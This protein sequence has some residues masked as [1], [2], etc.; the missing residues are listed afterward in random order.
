MLEKINRQ[1]N[2]IRKLKLL[3]L[4]DSLNILPHG[5]LT[6]LDIL[7]KASESH[8]GQYITVSDIAKQ[9]GVTRPA[10]SRTLRKLEMKGCIQ[11]LTDRQDRRITYVLITEDGRTALN[12]NIEIITSFMNRV[13]SHFEPNEIDEY[14]NLSKKLV[15]SITEE[16][17]LLLK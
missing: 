5:E 16:E 13:F 17:K 4:S 11:R 9:L 10:I 6:I 2:I 8:P 7:W 15:D 1:Y 12:E 3:N 14:F